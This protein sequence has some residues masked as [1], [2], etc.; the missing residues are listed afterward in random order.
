MRFDQ[1]PNLRAASSAIA[2][3]AALIAE[4]ILIIYKRGKTLI[5]K[6]NP[7]PIRWVHAEIYRGFLLSVIQ[8]EDGYIARID[9]FGCGWDAQKQG[10]AGLKES[11]AEAKAMIDSDLNKLIEEA[12]SQDQ[13]RASIL[14]ELLERG[15]I[16]H[17][18]AA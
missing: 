9:D 17:G 16:A 6:K 3:L 1:C 4:L 12:E 18:I 5:Y 15:S 13:L 10:T 11:L 8:R 2:L 14:S 7:R